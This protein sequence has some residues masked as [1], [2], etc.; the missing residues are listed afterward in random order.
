MAIQIQTDR[1]AI[2]D[3]ESKRGAAGDYVLSITNAVIAVLFFISSR[4][5]S[6]FCILQ[7]NPMRSG[8]QILTALRPIEIETNAADRKS[9]LLRFESTAQIKL[10]KEL[11]TTVW[12]PFEFANCP[13]R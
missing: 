5:Y 6:H 11:K 13:G 12:L 4:E 1:A 3:A 2:E 8:R 7:D 10:T 9:G